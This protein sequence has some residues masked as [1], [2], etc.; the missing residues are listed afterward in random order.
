MSR[1]A[2]VAGGSGPIG[3]AVAGRL[4]ASGYRVALHFHRRPDAAA[5]T[6][7]EF[8]DGH[9]VVGADLGDPASLDVAVTRVEDELGPVAVLVN[10]AHPGRPEQAPVAELSVGGLAAQLSAV[11]AHA[12]LCARVVPGMRSAGWGRVVYVSGA[13]MARPA[14]GYGAYGAAKAAASV[15][16]RYLAVEE[17]RHGITANVVA[18][19]RVAVAG[20]ELTPAQ[21]A[22]ATKLRERMALPAFPDPSDVADAVLTFVNS[23]A[24]TGQTL[25][26]TGGEPI[27]G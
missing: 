7:A 8:G 26:V 22:L 18:P 15:L 16:T 9:L 27:D 10:S 2:L 20:E 12:A 17:G 3:A 21:R 5:K 4:V 25:W 24:L 14:P 11:G 13:L 6:M 19:G 23:G 1:V